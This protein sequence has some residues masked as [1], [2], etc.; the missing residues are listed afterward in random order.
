MFPIVL[1]IGLL[2]AKPIPGVPAEC[3]G[4]LDCRPAQVRVLHRG[5]ETTDLLVDGVRLTMPSVRVMT[6]FQG[7]YCYKRWKPACRGEN[8][9][10]R[11]CAT[12]AIEAGRFASAELIPRGHERWLVLPVNQD[13]SACHGAAR[14][15]VRTALAFP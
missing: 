15:A 11:D 10:S 1:L 9:I 3:C 7:Y 12:C 5:P 2:F 14:G 13:C 8:I 6:A 4:T